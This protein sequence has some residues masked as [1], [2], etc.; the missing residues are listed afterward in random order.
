MLCKKQIFIHDFNI[1][2]CGHASCSPL[3]LAALDGPQA[4]LEKLGAWTGPLLKITNAG[5]AAWFWLTQPNWSRQ[6]RD[7]VRQTLTAGKCL[8]YESVTIWV[9]IRLSEFQG[10]LWANL[11]TPTWQLGN[12]ECSQSG[13]RRGSSRSPAGEST[14]ASADRFYISRYML[15]AF[16]DRQRIRFSSRLVWCAKHTQKCSFKCNDQLPFRYH[17]EVRRKGRI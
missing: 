6:E 16:L 14:G 17:N 12:W 9:W 15:L 1:F 3:S 7:S 2:L 8:H 10:C 13:R 4:E 5:A 11:Q